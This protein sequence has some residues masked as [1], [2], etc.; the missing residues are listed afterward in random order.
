[1]PGALLEQAGLVVIEGVD[2]ISPT[3]LS[4][5][6][7]S[8]WADPY[9]GIA[10]TQAAR[11]GSPSTTAG[12]LVAWCSDGSNCLIARSTRWHGTPNGQTYLQFFSY[13]SSIAVLMTVA[14]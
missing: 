13:H 9:S 2:R 6:P 10:G 1:M 7:S 12:V 5:S 3:A 4:G 14:V 11:Q 8:P